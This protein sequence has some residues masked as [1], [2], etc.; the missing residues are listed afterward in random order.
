MIDVLVG[1]SEEELARA[2]G[3]VRERERHMAED[4]RH[5]QR[6]VSRSAS[7]LDGDGDDSDDRHQIAPIKH[8]VFSLLL[9]RRWATS[10]FMDFLYLGI[11]PFV[12]WLFSAAPN[13]VQ[14]GHPE[15]QELIVQVLLSWMGPMSVIIGCFYLDLPN[16]I[17][18]LRWQQHSCVLHGSEAM[19]DSIVGLL[20]QSTMFVVPFTC[21]CLSTGLW[22]YVNF[23]IGLEVSSFMIAT[24]IFSTFLLIFQ[25]RRDRRMSRQWREVSF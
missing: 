4:R 17:R 15:T 5:V 7:S 23:S 24:N 21:L 19:I 20:G 6:L 2:A 18:F 9:K 8:R 12:L 1:L 3:L 25:V 13:W 14:G 16:W 22:E 11:L 10:L